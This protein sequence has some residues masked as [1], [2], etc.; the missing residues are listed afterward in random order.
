MAP[1][2]NGVSRVRQAPFSIAA[3]E[4]ANTDLALPALLALWPR[5][6]ADDMR[7][8]IDGTLRPNGYRL[9]GL[10]TEDEERAAS[11]VGY[12]LQYSL[13][14][15]QSLYLVD[16]STLPEWRG[17]GF[18][19]R[20]AE[21]IEEEARRLGCTAIHLDSGVGPER[22]AAHRLYMRHH[23]R[24]SCHHFSKQLA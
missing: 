8:F 21:W 9:V 24:I 18:A 3:I 23:F 1:G 15:G 4:E 22:S 11:I 12:R 7:A 6:T 13:W 5:Y 16:V 14:L 19:D 17:H 10:F 20:L 2:Q